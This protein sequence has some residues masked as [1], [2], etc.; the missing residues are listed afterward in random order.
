MSRV[1][2]R[3]LV[4]LIPP[5][6]LPAPHPARGL[7]PHPSP[8][9]PP[10]APSG[11]GSILRVRQ[12]TVSYT[13]GMVHAATTRGA[14]PFV[15]GAL[16]AIGVVVDKGGNLSSALVR[17]PSPAA[18]GYCELALPLSSLGTG[19]LCENRELLAL[20][21]G[22]DSA[23]VVVRDMACLLYTSPSPRDS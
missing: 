17:V 5:P 23:G 11:S 9:I 21:A 16:P 20:L 22:L 15:T 13:E 8:S 18:C 1:V 4:D 10:V 2:A 19:K 3:Q 7:T 14:V 12:G 6:T